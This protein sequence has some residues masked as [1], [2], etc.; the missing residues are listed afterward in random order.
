MA[1]E[2]KNRNKDKGKQRNI[3]RKYDTSPK[4]HVEMGEESEFV[5]LDGKKNKRKQK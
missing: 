2:N 1:E 5:N 4:H 3:A